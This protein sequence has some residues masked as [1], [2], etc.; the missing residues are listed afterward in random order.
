[1]K[2]IGK[3]TDKIIVQL[4][5]LANTPFKINTFSNYWS[6][7]G[8]KYKLDIDDEFGFQVKLPNELYLQV[9]PLGKEIIDASLPFY[10]WENYDFKDHTNLKEYESQ[11]RD[12]ESSFE[13]AK[14]IAIKCLPEPI[15]NWVDLDQ[16]SHKAVIWEGEY[17][18][19]ILQQA[20]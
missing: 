1:M 14:R 4:F 16:D 12:F 5:Q 2:K 13:M 8:W 11:L 19:L 3:I 10:Y 15:L 7:V 17:G 18:L 20:N 9:D 6:S